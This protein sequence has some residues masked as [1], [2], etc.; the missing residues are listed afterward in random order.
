[1]QEKLNNRGLTILITGLNEERLIE[2]TVVVGDAND[3][4]LSEV[5]IS[6]SLGSSLDFIIENPL[7]QRLAGALE[8]LGLGRRNLGTHRSR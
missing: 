1:M 2:L 5:V 3:I 6:G 4:C 8:F 7:Y